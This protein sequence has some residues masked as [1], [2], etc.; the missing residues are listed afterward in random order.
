MDKDGG[1]GIGT[2]NVRPPGAL[3]AADAVGAVVADSCFVI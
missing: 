1:A 2:G 3:A